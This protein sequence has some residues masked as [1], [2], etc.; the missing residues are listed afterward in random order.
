[1][2]NSK[3]KWN[4]DRYQC[5]CKKLVDW[6]SCEKGYMWNL[7]TC[8]YNSNKTCEIGEYLDTKYCACKECVIDNLALICEDEILNT[9]EAMPLNSPDRKGNDGYF[10]HT[11]SLVIVCLFLLS[12]LL[13]V[14]TTIKNVG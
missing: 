10:I 5:E 7:S 6:N 3:Q 8:G 14:T 13:I 2:C 12:F 4:C 11:S 9:T 1:M